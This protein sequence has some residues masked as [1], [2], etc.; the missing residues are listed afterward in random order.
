MS[1]AL[2]AKVSGELLNGVYG[3]GKAEIGQLGGALMDQYGLW[4]WLGDDYII[5]A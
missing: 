5:Y 2:P 4:N 3:L 1:N